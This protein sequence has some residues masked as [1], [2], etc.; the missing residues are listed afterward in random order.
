ML[1]EWTNEENFIHSLR[2]V[3]QTFFKASSLFYLVPELGP[4]GFNESA[5]KKF[6]V[7]Q[8]SLPTKKGIFY[9]S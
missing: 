1:D 9:S 3:F 2:P 6:S 4:Q 8:F 5:K 7:R